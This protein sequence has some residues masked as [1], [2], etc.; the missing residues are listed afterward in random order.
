MNYDKLTRALASLYLI[1]GQEKPC[2][3]DEWLRTSR[4]VKGYSVDF[5]KIYFAIEKELGYKAQ[6]HKARLITLLVF[7]KS[8]SNFPILQSFRVWES[9]KSKSEERK[10]LSLLS[11]AKESEIRVFAAAHPRL[12]KKDILCLAKDK[13]LNVVFTVGYRTGLP[14]K[15]LDVI[16]QRKL[17]LPK[18]VEENIKHEL[19]KRISL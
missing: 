3:L 14:E 8:N 13:D 10:R 5:H 18:T 15:V 4:W 12:S 1:D 11:R 17:N 16:V 19:A 6:I 7:G 9:V 2:Q